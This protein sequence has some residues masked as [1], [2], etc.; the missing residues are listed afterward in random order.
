[1]AHLQLTLKPQQSIESSPSIFTAC[2]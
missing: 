2:C 1:M